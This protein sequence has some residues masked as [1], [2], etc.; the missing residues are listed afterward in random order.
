MIL[1]ITFVT[2]IIKHIVQSF[3]ERIQFFNKNVKCQIKSYT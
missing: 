1:D 3:E 2:N